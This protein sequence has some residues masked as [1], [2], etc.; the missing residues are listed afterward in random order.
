MSRYDVE[1]PEKVRR[2]RRRRPKFCFGEQTEGESEK[3]GRKEARQTDRLRNE[4]EK[5]RRL[6]K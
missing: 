5:R 1:L 2:K 6:I 3:E 4:R